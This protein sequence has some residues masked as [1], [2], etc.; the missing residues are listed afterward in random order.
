MKLGVCL[1]KVFLDGRPYRIFAFELFKSCFE[2]LDSL[3]Y[4]ASQR[5]FSVLYLIIKLFE[6]ISMGRICKLKRNMGSRNLFSR[7]NDVFEQR[8]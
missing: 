3:P 4:S 5:N 8:I 2:A 6:P 7:R 1:V